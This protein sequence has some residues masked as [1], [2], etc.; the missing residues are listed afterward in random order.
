[1]KL[2]I[3]GGRNNVSF[4]FIKVMPSKLTCQIGRLVMLDTE[5]S[6][7]E[8]V[9]KG[10]DIIKGRKNIQRHVGSFTS[11]TIY[12]NDI[13]LCDRTGVSILDLKSFATKY[14]FTHKYFNDLHHFYR[15]GNNYYIVAT[16]LDSVLVFDEKFNFK[17]AKHTVGND[18]WQKFD[19]N[20]D[21][22]LGSTKPHEY[23]PNHV[24]ELDDKIW[25]T[26]FH[27]KKA[28]CLE[29]KSQ[30]F[31]IEVGNPHDG[32]VIENQVLFTTTNGNVLSFD[33]ITRKKNWRLDLNEIEKVDTPLGWCRGVYMKGDSVFVGFTA[34]R[35]TKFENN[36]S[37]VI[38][39]NFERLPSRIVEYSISKK[40]K[41]REF[42]LPRNTM[43]V[44]FSI[45]EL[46]D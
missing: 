36:I 14:S 38:G 45:K 18:V 6:T 33:P 17:C 21:F 15:K 3:T 31:D 2:L 16:G 34:L 8:V 12:G 22:R 42:I 32:V 46:D 25:V 30:Y 28:F 39:K 37:W 9:K 1:M 24:F 20:V 23:H 29:D 41:I 7:F 4:V 26:S 35:K 11:T 27:S 13:L 5:N 43:N 19:K 40:S 10:N 44:V